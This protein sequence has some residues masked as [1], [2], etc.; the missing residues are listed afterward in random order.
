VHLI[1]GQEEAGIIY[2]THIAEN[3]SF[4]KSYLYMDVG[5]GLYYQ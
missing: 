5:G 4:S 1:N 3:L 2:E